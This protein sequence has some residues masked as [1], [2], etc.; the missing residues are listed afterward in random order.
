MPRIP[1]TGL[2]L[3][4]SLLPMAVFVALRDGQETSARPDYGT[5]VAPIFKAHCSPCHTGDQKA[6]G[7]SLASYDSLKKG[8]ISG[9]AMVAGSSGKSLLIHR[10]LGDDGQPRMPMGFKPLAERDIKLIRDWIDQ[11]AKAPSQSSEPKHWAFIPPKRPPIPGNGG[12]PIDSFVLARLKR[13]GLRPSPFADKVTLLRRVT[14]DLIGLPPSPADVDAFMA[15]K[16][17]NAYEKV[18]DRLLAS[19]HYGERMALPWLDA[20]RYADSNGFQQDGDTFQY[21][22]RD[23]VVK[24]L[25]ANM[26]FD[27]FTIEQLAGDLLPNPTRDQLVATAFNRNHMLNGEGGAIP[28]EQRS[29]NLFDR[30]DTTASTWL[31]LTMGCARCHDHKYDP[32]TQGDY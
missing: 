22:W 14:F 17:P 16:K 9:P 20:A 23:W 8:G 3:A 13:E 6:G 19:P 7:L 2:T 29:V 32:L 28:E 25:N 1:A 21:V 26:P 4:A 10:V 15:D 24:A 18:V 27:Q 12:S 5:H 11:G 31:S 30:V